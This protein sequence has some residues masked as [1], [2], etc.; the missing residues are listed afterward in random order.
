MVHITKCKVENNSYFNTNVDIKAFN[1][2][3]TKSIFHLKQIKTMHPS[4]ELQC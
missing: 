1:T 3:Q 4:A 2:N